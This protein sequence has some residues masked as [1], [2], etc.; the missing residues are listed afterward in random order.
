V[1]REKLFFRLKIGLPDAGRHG[2]GG[3]QLNSNGTKDEESRRDETASWR[4][5]RA[6]KILGVSHERLVNSGGGEDG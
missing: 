2:G 4:E 6:V 5:I 3:R 1:R